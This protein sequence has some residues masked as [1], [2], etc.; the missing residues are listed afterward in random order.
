M[1]RK[2]IYLAGIFV[3]FFNL[4]LCSQNNRENMQNHIRNYIET[5]SEIYNR[6]IQ[7]L[8][9]IHIPDNYFNEYFLKETHSAQGLFFNL[10]KKK[11]LIYTSKDNGNINVIMTLYPTPLAARKALVAMAEKSEKNNSRQYSMPWTYN[12]MIFIGDMYAPGRKEPAAMFVRSN[13]VVDIVADKNILAGAVDEAFRGTI[14][15]VIEVIAKEIDWEICQGELDYTISLMT[16]ENYNRMI[17]S[18][19]EIIMPEKYEIL[20]TPWGTILPEEFEYFLDKTEFTNKY[21]GYIYIE[22]ERENRIFIVLTLYST[23]EEARKRVLMEVFRRDQILSPKNETIGDISA[24][25]SGI[26]FSRANLTVSMFSTAINPTHEVLPIVQ[27]MDRKIM[28]R[29]K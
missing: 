5:G 11:H 13:V 10:I 18:L 27:E 16:F 28:A 26:L 14:E 4:T 12:R 8:A 6:P 29:V 7:S 21:K 23:N 1:S 20:S 17:Q 24:E 25:R 9:E 3:L 15:S 22:H 2:G 19:D